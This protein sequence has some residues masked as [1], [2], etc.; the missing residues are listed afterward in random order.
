[1]NHTERLF[2]LQMPRYLAGAIAVVIAV[3]V[4]AVVSSIVRPYSSNASPPGP[5]PAKQL[6]AIRA[7][8]AGAERSSKARPSDA[9]P[10]QN[11]RGW[12]LLGELVGAEH[13]VWLYSSPNGP[14]YTVC[15]GAGKILQENLEAEASTEIRASISPACGQPG[16]GGADG[17]RQPRFLA[18]D[19]YPA[20]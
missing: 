17:R 8:G 7:G 20:P 12:R 15:T 3:L 4:Y 6:P 10:E 13:R 9:A 5:T 14:R 19:S 2:G 11:S 18:D 1:M 16:G